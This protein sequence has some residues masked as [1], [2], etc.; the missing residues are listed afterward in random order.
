M[1]VF[2]HLLVIA[3]SAVVL[4]SCGGGEASSGSGAE[5][6][7]PVVE[8]E[9]SVPDEVFSN[10]FEDP[11][12]DSWQM[13][14]SVIMK[15]G[16]V[17]NKKIADIGAGT[18]YFSLRLAAKGA[19]VIAIDIDENFLQHIDEE[20]IKLPTASGSIETRKTIPESPNIGESEADGVL[21]VN[22]SYFLPERSAYFNEIKKGLKVGG[23]LV[24]V[25]FKPERSPVAPAD[26]LWIPSSRLVNELK[27]VGF[28]IKEVDSNTLPYQY[29]ITAIKK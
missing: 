22:T 24:V 2:R 26:N 3:W 12:R 21:V 1:K 25:D 23:R 6:E 10:E 20:A 11:D 13:P 16:E 8:E 17:K 29:I 14:D 4:M 15:L 19:D 7:S 28:T 9:A 5:R 18:G 27:A